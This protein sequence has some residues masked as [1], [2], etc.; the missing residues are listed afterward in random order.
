MLSVG[1]LAAA[2]ASLSLAVHPPIPGTELRHIAVPDPVL[3]RRN[4]TYEVMYPSLP[5]TSTPLPAIFYFHGQSG[6]LADSNSFAELGEATGQFM[7]IAA[8]GLSEGLPDS[9][10]WTVGAEGRADVCTQDCEAVVFPSCT[11]A[12]R[13]SRCNWATCYSDLAFIQLLL[14]EVRRDFA[15][16]SSRFY[17][18]GASNGAMLALHLAEALPGRFRAV[19]PW[20]GAYLRGQLP[21]AGLNGTSL[22]L[23]QGGKD[24]TIPEQGGESED[25]YLYES[26]NATAS[27]FG[28]ANGC[29]AT[30]E[31]LVHP[32]DNHPPHAC[33]SR[34]SCQHGIRVVFCDF[35]TQEHGFWPTWA[36]SMTW[37]FLRTQVGAPPAAR[38]VPAERG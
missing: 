28:A 12:G 6:T 2:S 37:W 35:P 10:A 30:L 16:D 38:S 33:V 3:G 5:A 29:S 8:K 14:A 21:A 1:L 11:R 32:F 4:R 22:L 19:V 27:A 17:A 20:Y 24:R 7:T 26:S 31:P 23:L 25:H 18:V 9:S 15:V 13:V 34:A 36:E